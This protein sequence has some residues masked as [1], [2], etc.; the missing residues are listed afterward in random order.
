[1]KKKTRININTSIKIYIKVFLSFIFNKGKENEIYFKKALKSFFSTDNILITSQGRVAAFNI[2]KIILSEKKKEILISPYTLTEVINAII[3]AGGKPVYVEIDLKKGLPLEN[4]L[5]KKINKNTAGLVLTHLYSNKED[6][7]NFYNKYNKKIIII[8]DVAIN[9]GAKIDNQKLLGTIFDYGFYSF[10]V[11]KNL[12]TFHGGAIIS[13]DKSKIYEIEQNLKKNINYPI[14]SSVKL[15]F[16]CILIDIFYNKYVY[17]FLTHYILNISFKKLD[18]LMYPGVYPKFFKSVPEHYNY[19]FQGNFAIAGIDNLKKIES[20]S[21]KKIDKVKFYELYLN[22]DLIINDFSFHEINSFLEYPILLK[23]N[24]NIF[25]SKQLL[26]IGYDIRHTWYVNSA[27]YLKFN[28]NLSDF[29]NCEYLH[30][31]VLSLPTHDQILEKDIIKICNLINF[32][33][34]SKI[35]N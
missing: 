27:R 2:F 31:K 14:I 1:M 16:F 22:K 18:N 9:F 13:K 33:E 4:D 19:K 29:P 8:E 5:E 28:Y 12:C 24:K 35:N 6:I 25:L 17:N 26:K 30:E 20:I 21:K 11:M 15:I 32:H 34:N 23:K 3:Y 7:L 10:G